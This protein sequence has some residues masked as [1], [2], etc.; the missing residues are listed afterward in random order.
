MTK[1]INKKS[2]AILLALLMAVSVFAG[3]SIPASADYDPTTDEL[4]SDYYY[5]PGSY[6]IEA[7][8]I[9][10]LDDDITDATI[11]VNVNGDTNYVTI[12]GSGIDSGDERSTITIDCAA[13][14]HLRLEDLYIKNSA[15]GTSPDHG[16]TVVSGASAVRFTGAGNYLD[17][18][19][20][21][22]LES[23]TYVSSAV[24]AVNA[25]TTLNITGADSSRF[26]MYKYTQGCGIGADAGNA[27]GNINIQSGNLFFKG[28]K[29]GAII[30]N[31]TCG[32]TTKEGQM[33]TITISG[34]NIELA[35]M[36]QGAAIGGSRMSKGN[37]VAIT[38]GNV[39][40]LTD[41][42]GSAIGA[43]AQL[44]STASN[45]GSLTLGTGASLQVIRTGNS[46]YGNYTT[47]QYLN[48]TLVMYALQNGNNG[49]ALRQCKVPVSGSSVTIT[50]GTTTLY[51]GGNPTIYPYVGSTTSTV[52]NW[53]FNNPVTGYVYIY[54]TAGTHYITV[55]N[56]S[57]TCTWDNTTETFT[58]A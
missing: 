19:G 57:Y 39:S 15:T 40:I 3:V 16:G 48:D 28:S 33:G 1:I 14:T 29:T 17:I 7:S 27:N 51:S 37:T 11:F 31:D 9:Y 54:L 10:Y 23:T 47:T 38:G 43:G 21:V 41:Y 12:K 22:L 50:E 20:D 13:G 34:G 44:A 8:G 53:D 4:V 6:V 32:D 18:S 5:S 25:G 55:N 26:Y 36:S 52:A 58:V 24:V 56:T 42:T 35:T 45:N 30:G 2:L 49:T 46:L